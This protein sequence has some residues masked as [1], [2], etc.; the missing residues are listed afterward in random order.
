MPDDN[1]LRNISRSLFLSAF[2]QGTRIRPA[3]IER[4]VPHLQERIV[5]TGSIL[6]RVNDRAEHLYFIQDGEVELSRDQVPSIIMQGK[7][8]LG[9]LECSV[10]L[11]RL[12]TATMLRTAQVVM[13]PGSLWHDMFEDEPSMGQTAFRASSETL[14]RL[15]ARLTSE[16]L[17]IAPAAPIGPTWSLPT[18][19]LDLVER[20]LVLSEVK[21]FRSSG[22]Q[23]LTMLAENAEESWFADAEAFVRFA[24]RPRPTLLLA[25]ALVAKR[26]GH[27]ATVTIEPNCSIP[28]P[29][30]A[31]RSLWS[32]E[33]RGPVRALSFQASVL[34]D[35]FEEHPELTRSVLAEMWQ[36]RDWL[37]S[38]MKTT[39]GKVVL[40]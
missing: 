5:E 20:M 25:G 24:D 12:R 10:D 40:R 36:E 23:S 28:L 18:E 22:I 6:Y 4:L 16:Q 39:E 9:A 2:S 11:P 32:F 15:Y 26:V 14:A 3:L 38:N 27:T 31:D 7:V 34:L 33:D 29:L 37:L 13:A 19:P 21:A 30:L 35:E 1:Y 17:R 8:L